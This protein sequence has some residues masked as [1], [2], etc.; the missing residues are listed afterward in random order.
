[1]I[2]LNH[3][4]Q[5]PSLCLPVTY[6]L[7]SFQ[8]YNYCHP[9]KPFWFHRSSISLY[10]EVIFCYSNVILWIVINSWIRGMEKFI[11]CCLFFQS[12]ILNGKPKVNNKKQSTRYYKKLT[13]ERKA[14]RKG[15]FWLVGAWDFKIFTLRAL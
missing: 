2:L 14:W 4:I 3:S 9:I 13:W 5:V 10:K 1:M 15:K 7:F 11:L 12:M 6:L 8:S